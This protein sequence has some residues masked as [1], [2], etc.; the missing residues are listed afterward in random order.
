MM[1]MIIIMMIMAATLLMIMMMMVMMITM[2]Q[3]CTVSASPVVPES[4]QPSPPPQCELGSRHRRR[5]APDSLAG[6]PS[7]AP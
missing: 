2:L 1:T 5:H 7:K 3:M 6:T 4:L